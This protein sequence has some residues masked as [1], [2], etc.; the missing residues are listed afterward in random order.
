VQ[1]VSEEGASAVP[2][3][4]ASW[5]TVRLSPAAAG[6]E[7]PELDELYVDW[8]QVVHNCTHANAALGARGGGWFLCPALS[9]IAR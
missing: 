4:A 9:T 6:S 5:L 3:P 8:N 2:S 7:A 1:P